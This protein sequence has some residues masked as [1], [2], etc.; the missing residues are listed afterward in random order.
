MGEFPEGAEEEAVV[1][2]AVLAGRGGTGCNRLHKRQ[3]ELVPEPVHIPG[4]DD[5]WHTCIGYTR[6]RSVAG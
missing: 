5:P 4:R 2:V 3:L 6:H 1:N